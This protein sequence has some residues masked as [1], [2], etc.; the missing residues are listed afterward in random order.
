MTSKVFPVIRATTPAVSSEPYHAFCSLLKSASDRSAGYYWRLDGSEAE[1]ESLHHFLGIAYDSFD[2][3]KKILLAQPNAPRSTHDLVVK[4]AD[5]IGGK[6][7]AEASKYNYPYLTEVEGDTKRR[8]QKRTYLRLGCLESS[9]HKVVDQYS[10]KGDQASLCHPPSSRNIPRLTKEERDIIERLSRI[11][12]EDSEILPEENRTDTKLDNRVNHHNEKKEYSREKELEFTLLNS[13]AKTFGLERELSHEERMTRQVRRLLRDYVLYMVELAMDIPV[14]TCTAP[15]SDVG[16]AEDEEQ[17]LQR[18]LK[19]VFT[20]KQRTL[21]IAANN[22]KDQLLVS[23]PYL[24]TI[25]G[26]VDAA[27]RSKWIHD[28][29]PT[30]NYRLAMMKFM[31]I[32]FQEDFETICRVYEYQPKTIIETYETEGLAHYIGLDSTQL[33]KSFYRPAKMA[34]RLLSPLLSS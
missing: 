30:N 5:D 29:L 15:Q 33:E 3:I 2:I 27:K 10:S 7:F 17:D 21:T 22:G 16:T 11:L 4:L 19:S 18:Q 12:P 32:H 9:I 25:D 24:Q 20:R 6:P 28:L 13:I 14:P 23:R 1:P 26:F 34:L 8:N 31:A